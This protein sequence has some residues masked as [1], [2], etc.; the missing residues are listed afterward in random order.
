MRFVTLALSFLAILGV[1]IIIYA[2]ASWASSFGN[3]EKVTKA[4]KMLIAA[5]IGLLIITIAWTITSYVIN[6]GGQLS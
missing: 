6:F 3:E 2:G 4:R 5:A 1:V